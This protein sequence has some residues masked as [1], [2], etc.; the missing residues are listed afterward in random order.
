MLE[1]TSKDSRLEDLLP[2]AVKGNEPR[3]MGIIS[4]KTK[5]DLPPGKADIADR[6]KLDGDFQIRS[7]HFTDPGIQR[8][9][10]GLSR[11]GRGQPQGDEIQYD[12]TNIKG[13]LSCETTS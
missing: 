13:H 12:A 11:R 6:L 1:V 7:A 4:L 3:L 8:K 5:F 9:I 10:L 2:L